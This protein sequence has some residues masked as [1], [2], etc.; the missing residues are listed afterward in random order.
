VERVSMGDH[1]EKSQHALL[2]EGDEN[3]MVSSQPLLLISFP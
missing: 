2:N 3:E 1:L